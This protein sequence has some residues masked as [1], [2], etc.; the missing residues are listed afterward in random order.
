MDALP[1]ALEAYAPQLPFGDW[2]IVVFVDRKR[3]LIWV[4]RWHSSKPGNEMRQTS[5]PVIRLNTGIRAF[6]RHLPLLAERL[7]QVAVGSLSEVEIVHAVFE[8]LAS[9]YEAAPD[10]ADSESLRGN[11]FVDFFR[12]QERAALSALA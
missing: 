6:C 2:Q 11:E 8:V 4:A 5:D 9:A 12:R 10:G 1:L 3:Q 7:A